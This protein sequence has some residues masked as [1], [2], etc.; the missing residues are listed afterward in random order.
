MQILGQWKIQSGH[1]GTMDDIASPS[2]LFVNSVSLLKK[3]WFIQEQFAWCG[4]RVQAQIIVPK[5]FT[6]SRTWTG[7]FHQVGFVVICICDW[8]KT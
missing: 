4:V 2:C 8:G 6:H 5:N 1:W 3:S 7:K